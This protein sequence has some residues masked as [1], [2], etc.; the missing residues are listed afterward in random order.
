MSPH[1]AW[2]DEVR[3]NPYVDQ[4][5]GGFTWLRFRG[6][7]EREYREAQFAQTQSLLRITLAVGT[8]LWLLFAVL[9]HLLI[10]S[11]ERWWMSAVRLVVLAV[12]LGCG[13]LL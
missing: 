9:D 13:A 8:V 3:P 1:Q 2:L 11:S 7:L 10:S 12:L 5:L 6:P 4:L